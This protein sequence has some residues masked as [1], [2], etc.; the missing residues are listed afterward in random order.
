METARSRDP[1]LFPMAPR[2]VDST[3]DLPLLLK[4]QV[5]VQEIHP[6]RISACQDFL[7][8]SVALVVAA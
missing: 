2:R 8:V 7:S 1:W 5:A 4:E 6:D 3:V